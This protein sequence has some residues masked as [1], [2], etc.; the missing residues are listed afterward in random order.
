MNLTIEELLVVVVGLMG[1]LV[2]LTQLLTKMGRWNINLAGT[3]RMFKLLDALLAALDVDRE[4]L[5][6]AFILR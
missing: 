4:P 6:P 5:G 3:Q 1:N 2:I